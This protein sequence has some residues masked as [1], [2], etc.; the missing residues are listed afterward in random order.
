MNILFRKN[1]GGE[2][3]G[4][5]GSKDRFGKAGG[6]GPRKSKAAGGRNRMNTALDDHYGLRTHIFLSP[7][8]TPDLEDDFVGGGP[9]QG[10][11]TSRRSSLQYKFS[12]QQ[13]RKPSAP[14]SDFGDP[15]VL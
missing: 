4:G 1:F 9:I 14:K 11:L 10:G 6:R 5:G 15:Q 12:L 8:F 7:A 13:K 3:G 2:G